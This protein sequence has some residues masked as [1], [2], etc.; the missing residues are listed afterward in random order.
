MAGDEGDWVQKSLGGWRERV[1]RLALIWVG[2]PGGERPRLLE[3]RF[4]VR[5]GDGS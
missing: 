3:E 1:E 5:E 4:L 2:P